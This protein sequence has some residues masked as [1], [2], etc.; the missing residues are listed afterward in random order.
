MR[1]LTSLPSILW[2][3][4][5]WAITWALAPPPI[6]PLVPAPIEGPEDEMRNVTI[7]SLDENQASSEKT[8]AEFSMFAAAPLGAQMD[9]TGWTVACS[10]SYKNY[11]CSRV[12]DGNA[13]TFWHTDYGVTPMPQ[14]PHTITIDMK[15]TK[16]VTGL[17]MRPRQ[18]GVNGF[19]ARHE[20]LLSTDGT[21]FGTPVSYG[22][23]FGDSTEKF[24]NFEP[25]AARYVRLRA[26]TEAAGND[27]WASIAELNLYAAEPKAQNTVGG[28][29]GATIDFPIVPVAAFV[30]PPTGNLVT[31]SAWRYDQFS[32]LDRGFTLTATWDRSSNVITQRTVQNT[33]HD[34]FCPGIS[35]DANGQM[36]VTGGN[37]AAR[38]SIYDLPSQ[39]W[40]SG[41]D[42]QIPRGYQ[43]SVTL[44]N[45]RIFTI[46]GS[47]SGGRIDKPGEIY[48]PATQRWTLLPDA[49]VTPMLTQDHQGLFRSDN[50]AWLFGWKDGTVFQAGPS[51]AMH[52]IYTNGTG[53]TVSAG[54]RNN[55]PDQMCGN[56]VM[57]DA[58]AGKILAYGGST[59]YQDRDATTNAHLITIRSP[60]QP[61]TVQTI[62]GGLRYSRIFH[63]SAVLPDGSVFLAG[64]QGYGVPFSDAQARLTPELY[65]PSTNSFIAQTANSIPRTY[66]SMALLL[67]DATVVVGG[68]GL[69]GGCT[70]NHFNAQ[71]FT[72]AY[73]YDAD[74]QLAARPAITAAGTTVRVGATLSFQTGGAISA[75]SLIRYGSATHSVNTD[76][77]R[78]PLQYTSRGASHMARIPNDPGIMTP[79]YWMLFVMDGNGVPSVARTVRVTL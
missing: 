66:H 79:G 56:A 6:P 49:K 73:L 9:R 13:A 71:V 61:A 2:L 62:P 10:T 72:P 5:L 57:F 20:V 22:T 21:N 60:G 76:Q 27:Q 51:T 34:M 44:S 70:T 23:W 12:L 64:G 28:T 67:P 25:R 68:G 17:A 78:V 65:R 45:G 32:G 59:S 8:L 58:V 74:G 53:N 31:W 54:S 47:W 36:V 55:S 3:S 37:D 50:H 46:G 77:R 24:S 4:G 69:C 75:A 43:S 41:P 19:I 48:D 26:L 42:M 29:W 63:N 15:A 30:D 18:S 52:W 16:V 39:G 40:I 14:P 11:P 7:A 35:M 1:Q 33:K 38:T